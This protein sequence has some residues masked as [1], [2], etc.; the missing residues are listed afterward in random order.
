ME[1]IM[2]KSNT[3]LIVLFCT[4]S[5][6]STS[7]ANSD[8]NLEQLVSDA[9]NNVS[10]INYIVSGDSTKEG[11]YQQTKQYYAD[12]LN[13]LNIQYV[14]NSVGGL[15]ADEWITGIDQA[16]SNTI[17]ETVDQAIS[18]TPGSGENTILEFSLGINDYFRDPNLLEA[19]LLATMK[20]GLDMYIA[21]RPKTE[22]ILVSPVHFN[23]SHSDKL[24]RIYTQLATDY[25]FKLINVEAITKPFYHTD[26]FYIDYVHPS[27]GGARRIVNYIM[28]QIV[29]P[30]YSNSIILPEY[31]PLEGVVNSAEL[32]LT[33]EVGHYDVNTGNA[34]DSTWQRL[35]QFE[36][37]PNRELTLVSSGNRP[38][39]IF[40]DVN[41]IKI[42]ESEQF[43]DS[44]TDSTLR[45]QI[46][47]N[48]KY[49]RAN[50][51]SNA[52][53]ITVSI[54]YSETPLHI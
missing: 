18:Q 44:P 25:G 54:K 27:A 7:F 43:H 47:S 35:P 40:L 12:L 34:Y 42:G 51:H 10:N 26:N 20:Q 6:I 5:A 45:V 1:I 52:D 53:I 24:N 11:R 21:A 22:I 4:W 17:N 2:K 31:I 28:S 23:A 8:N 38:D 39:I 37:I 19:S 30:Q 9:L 49:A 14:D 33:P 50:V 48:A 13:Q 36:V 16:S 3:C 15:D 41:E 29:P 46:P 32:A